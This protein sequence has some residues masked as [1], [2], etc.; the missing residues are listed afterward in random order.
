MKFEICG[1]GGSLLILE[2]GFVFQVIW[3]WIAGR[4]GISSTSVTM[5]TE[6]PCCLEDINKHKEDKSNLQDSIII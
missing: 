3:S 6:N 1:I 5:V 4:G 2:A